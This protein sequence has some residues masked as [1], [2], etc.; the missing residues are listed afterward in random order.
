[1]KCES[2]S[3]SVMSDSFWPHVLFSPARHRILSMEFSGQEFWEWVAISFYRGSCVPRD[4]T[5]SPSLQVDSWPLSHQGSPLVKNKLSINMG[6]FLDC[7]LYSAA[8]FIS[9][10]D[11]TTLLLN[12]FAV[13]YQSC[14][15]YFR[16]FPFLRGHWNELL[17]FNQ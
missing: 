8:L 14:F 13:I 2:V 6:L 16:S 9:F 7:L 5:R 12:N 15:G 1:M 11:N 17:K 3:R 10:Y 4:R